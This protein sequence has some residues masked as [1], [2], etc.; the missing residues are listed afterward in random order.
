[1]IKALPQK[2]LEKKL[3][4]IFSEYIRL[5]TVDDRGYCQCITCGKFYHWKDVHCG[6]F[7]PRGRKATRF[8]EM[9]CH[10]QCVHC[11]YHKHG[12]PDIYRLRLIEMYGKSKVEKLEQLAQMGGSYDS[13]WL[14]EKIN[15]YKEKVKQL[16]K[17][18][19]L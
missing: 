12:Q 16:K 15:Y 6:H 8:D 3:D 2:E 11:N 19:G 17:D 14:Q 10:P 7:I 4:R 13:F 9:N 5:R 18:K 1:M